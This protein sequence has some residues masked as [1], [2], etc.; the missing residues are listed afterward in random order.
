[1]TRDH[2]RVSKG[3][4]FMLIG[5]F[6]SLIAG[7]ILFLLA[8]ASIAFAVALVPLHWFAYILLAIWGYFSFVFVGYIG[9][10]VGHMF[11]LMGLIY[12]YTAAKGRGYR[13][14]TGLA[15][16]AMLLNPMLMVI[17]I[18]LCAVV[19]IKDD[20]LNH[21][22]THILFG[23][24][25][26]MLMVTQCAMLLPLFRRWTAVLAIIVYVIALPI[27]LLDIGHAIL[28]I[29]FNPFYPMTLYL[30]FPVMVFLNYGIIIMSMFCYAIGYLGVRRQAKKYEDEK[31]ARDVKRLRDIRS[32]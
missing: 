7:V 17:F 31:W 3:F 28:A 14:T 8:I 12:I 32:R 16:A 2:A 30:S 25:G 22:P 21:Y 27:I 24:A 15:L 19:F 13:A 5:L 18:L 6:I 26:S 4:L 23:F 29:A 20:P 9:V 1:M 11:N 10:R